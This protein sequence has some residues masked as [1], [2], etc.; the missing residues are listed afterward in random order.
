MISSGGRGMGE[1]RG[2]YV[3]AGAEVSP[4]SVLI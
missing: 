4:K 2:T 1:Q 3:L